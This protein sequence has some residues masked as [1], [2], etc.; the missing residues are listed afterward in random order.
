MALNLRQERRALVS[1][2]SGLAARGRAVD[3]RVLQYGVT[4]D[5]LRSILD[6][7][8]GWDVI[9]LSGHGAPGELLLER[10]DGAP[11]RVGAA[12]LA[13]LLD[14]AKGRLKLVALSAC[15]SAALAM[16]EQL[17]LLGLPDRGAPV[18]PGAARAGDLATE[19]SGRLR[20]AVL[21]M[22][23]PVADDFAAALTTRLYE[24]LADE[25]QPVPRA[26]GVALSRTMAELPSDVWPPLSAA[27]PALFGAR[28]AGLRLA[29]PHRAP[30]GPPD[31]G[32]LKMAAFPPSPER[33]VGRTAVM[34]R[35]SAALAARSG[36]PGVL[37]Y[38]MPGGGKTACALELAYGHEHAFDRLI[39]FR[40]PDEAGNPG[41]ELTSFALTLERGLPGLQLI[42]LLDA[43][44]QLASFLPRLTGLMKRHRVLVVVDNVESLLAES[45]HWRDPRWG[46]VI[47][48]LCA[49]DG[50]GRVV[51]TSRSVPA[52]QATAGTGASAGPPGLLPESV[53]AL[54]RD[55]TLLLLRELPHLN[56]LV[57]GRLA[58]IKKIAARKLAWSVLAIAQGHPKL[59]E[60]ADGQAADPARLDELVRA[61]DQAWRQAGGVP[62][63][64]FATGEARATEAD[65]LH[66]LGRWTQV[67]SDELTAGPR[68]LF[69]CLCCLEPID[70]FRPLVTSIWAG[71]WAR[72][73]LEGEP[74]S[75]D[76]ALRA[77]AA[78]GLIAIR[79]QTATTSQAYS[80]Q[81]A[82]AASGRELAGEQFR[83]AVDAGVIFYW[84]D[85]AEDARGREAQEATAGFIIHAGIAAAPYLI[86]QKQWGA[87]R[88]ML[89]DAFNRQQMKET[90]ATI[91][92][93]LQAIR[94]Q[95]KDL[96][97][98]LL[99]AKVMQLINPV[100]AESWTQENLKEALEQRDYR[101]AMGAAGQLVN[102]Y[103][104]TARLTEALAL[105]S[106]QADYARQCDPGPWTQLQSDVTRL[107][108]L[109][110]MG[111]ADQVLAEV[112]RLRARIRDYPP[113]PGPDEAVPV[114]HVQQ[115]LLATG[116]DAARMLGRWEEALD[117]NAA[118]AAAQR[119]QGA[120]AINLARTEYMDY[121]P[122]LQLDRADD[123]LVLLLQCR[124]IFERADDIEGL[125]HVFTALAHTEEL[126]GHREAAVGLE[127]DALRYKY[128]AGDVT[129][130]L[131][132]SHHNLGTLLRLVRLPADALAHHLAAA[133]VRDLTAAEG[134]DRSV[135]EA[136]EDLRDMGTGP[137]GL[138]SIAELSGR[139]GVVP[140]V[141]LGALVKALT[142]DHDA[143]EQ[144]LRALCERVRAQVAPLP[145]QMLL[146]A[147]V[148]SAMAAWDPVI[149][150]LLAAE[151]GDRDAA[152]SLDEQLDGYQDSPVWGPL[153]AA[154]RK[155]R[156][157]D[158]GPRLLQ[159]LNE[160]STA[161][162]TRALDALAGTAD[163]PVSLWTATSLGP[164][165]GAVVA[166]ARGN[167]GAAREARWRLAPFAVNPE[168]TPLAVVL[169]RIIG[170]DR[171]P[172]LAGQFERPAFEAVVLTV[173]RH[174][175]G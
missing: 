67:A 61:G 170:G 157:G 115:M 149:A 14:A 152:A 123:A 43:E 74:S 143:A 89:E 16:A 156:A 63:G 25:G 5:R 12:E 114:W 56:D 117:L 64:F 57:A 6:E 90:A 138:T 10:E 145:F 58:G 32:A 65:Y 136:A 106:Q 41:G 19:L 128:R 15:W 71:L 21:A 88:S 79:P 70:R 175:G 139:V 131:A 31:A 54:S 11:D 29:A 108:I 48:A 75:L 150:A 69:W 99:A 55:E 18:A 68:A 96:E 44:A 84:A 73:G 24:L 137:A 132:V 113:E 160:A 174:A 78:D 111:Q 37:L 94:A 45:G 82:V 51:L 151:G 35:A 9:H 59:L 77:L 30:A 20:C 163:I 85:V 154:L 107:Q 33:F 2:L 125:G 103:R 7:D 171:D 92:S 140:G 130:G 169:E 141:N 148:A 91:L 49:P 60:L 133:L 161:I 158:R 102:L 1:L 142:P 155:V 124:R 76:E 146:P 46:Q 126:R 119:A 40:A 38:G 39:W 98:D 101:T 134:V 100:T 147:D 97:A 172:G 34:A 23:Y 36:V 168:L 22:R 66:V 27:T 162:V 42:H 122:L 153:V 47:G 8:E 144:T 110:D 121:F 164:L 95:T 3:V 83:D 72:L 81:P 28:A 109:N 118:S 127:C 165:L 116:R 135:S 104:R 129:V 159:G 80:V 93:A 52:G 13:G 166:A 62:E 86:R 87:A 53:D 173:L 50:L 4:R 167:A 105:A 26:L 17:Q 120:S 112:Q